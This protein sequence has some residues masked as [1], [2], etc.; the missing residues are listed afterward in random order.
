MLRI[1]MHACVAAGCLGLTGTVASAQEVIH[2]MTGTVRSIDATQK[3]FTLFKDSGTLVTFKDMTD[4]KVRVANDKKVLPDAAAARAIDKKDAYVIVFY[5]GTTDNPT[6]VAVRALGHGP[7][8][9]TAGTVANFNGKD[10]SIS[11]KD[12]TGSIHS[13]RI[14]T[15]TVA[16][17]DFGVV[18]GLKFHAGKGDHVR[19]VGAV[20]SDSPTALFVS[21]M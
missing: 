11:V 20:T 1:L 10:R 16:E 2:A 14:S 6:A 12:E 8:T 3:T 4:A 15:D 5:Y 18:E 19:V 21:V 17:S 7:F 13:Y 9:A